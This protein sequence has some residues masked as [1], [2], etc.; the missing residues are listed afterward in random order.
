M[1]FRSLHT[2]KCEDGRTARIVSPIREIEGKMMCLIE[3]VAYEH[4][5][6]IDTDGKAATIY[7]LDDTEDVVRML[8][9]DPV[10]E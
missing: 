3:F 10:V 1:T 7:N 2:Y 4:I 5:A 8:D 9:E 6:I